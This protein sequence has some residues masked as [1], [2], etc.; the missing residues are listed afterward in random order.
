MNVIDGFI[1]FI[2]IVFV[3][4]FIPLWLRSRRIGEDDSVNW[5]RKPASQSPRAIG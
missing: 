1:I 3:A 2:G 4:G 5:D